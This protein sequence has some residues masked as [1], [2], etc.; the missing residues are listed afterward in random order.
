[1]SVLAQ[2]SAVSSALL[3]RPRLVLHAAGKQYRAARRAGAAASSAARVLLAAG[4]LCIP[5]LCSGDAAGLVSRHLQQQQQP[6]QRHTLFLL[7]RL[8]RLVSFM[9]IRQSYLVALAWHG[10]TWPCRACRVL[11][12]K[13]VRLLCA[14]RCAGLPCAVLLQCHGAWLEPSAAYSLAECTGGLAA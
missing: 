8:K 4:G 5:G 6:Q 7:P 13:F 9:F 2:Q 3:E 14:L 1:M 12:P 11:A 10:T